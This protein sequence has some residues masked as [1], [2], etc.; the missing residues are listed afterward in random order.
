MRSGL[1]RSV[2]HPPKFFLFIFVYFSRVN[3]RAVNL[4]KTI[5]YQSLTFMWSF[6]PI[7]MMIQ[8]R[9]LLAQQTENKK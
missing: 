4:N 7:S 3:H 5:E 6:I 8:C 1:I 9:Q 2:V